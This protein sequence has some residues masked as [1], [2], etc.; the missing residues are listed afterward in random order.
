MARHLSFVT[1]PYEDYKDF[2]LFLYEQISYPDHGF[3]RYV[4]SDSQVYVL[5]LE[6]EDSVM[7]TLRFTGVVI[8]PFGEV[9]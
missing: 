7:I 3:I 8:D 1:V 2:E 5:D 6:E 4:S 9:V